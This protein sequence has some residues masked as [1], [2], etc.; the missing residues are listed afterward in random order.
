MHVI[1]RY[2]SLCTARRPPQVL[3]HH[4]LKSILTELSTAECKIQWQTSHQYKV[5]VLCWVVRAC[6][7]LIWSSRPVRTT[8]SAR[9]LR[10]VEAPLG[11]DVAPV[12]Q[13]AFT[14][15]LADL[16]RAGRQ[17]VVIICSTHTAASSR[18]INVSIRGS[19]VS[20]WVSIVSS[21]V[22]NVSSRGSNVSSRVSN[23]TTKT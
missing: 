22:S 2:I 12:G 15:V 21:R 10:Q 6:A 9:P 23:T 5:T 19:N 18:V 1:C 8:E 20:S 17:R 4:R 16:A 3:T 13:L 7:L 11:E 14:A